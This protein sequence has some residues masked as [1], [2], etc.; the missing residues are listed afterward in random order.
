MAHYNPNIGKY[1][2]YGR[3]IISYKRKGQ[4][5]SLMSHNFI[6]GH[7]RYVT[8]ELTWSFPLTNYL[9]GYVDIFSGY[10]QSLIEYNHRTNSTGIGIALNDWV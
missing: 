1:L 10:G 9:K 5:F 2:G 3:I 7:A 8:G 4:V 6:E